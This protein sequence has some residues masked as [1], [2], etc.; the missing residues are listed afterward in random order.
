[1]QALSQVFQNHCAKSEFCR[2]RKA[3]SKKDGDKEFKKNK[4]REARM[5][6]SKQASQPA[7]E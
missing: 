7:S 3:G 2:E 4:K 5:E 6:A 1:M